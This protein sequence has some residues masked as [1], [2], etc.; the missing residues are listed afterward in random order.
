MKQDNTIKRDESQ[1][2]LDILC[3]NRWEDNWITSINQEIFI[4]I[5]KKNRVLSS[6]AHIILNNKKDN[7]L[8]NTPLYRVL[9]ESLLMNQ[10]DKYAYQE[11][12]NLLQIHFAK[13]QIDSCLLKGISLQGSIPR[14]M[15]DLDLLIHP[16]DLISAIT[17]LE[18]LGFIYQGHKRNI[19]MKRREIRNWKEL[20]TWSNQ[21]EFLH[22]QTGVLVELH[23]NFFER[24]RIY[25]FNLD[26]LLNKVDDFWE[27]CTWSES[28]QCK[29][30]SPED[31][32]LLL[33]IHNSIKR[34]APKGL[35]A[36][37]N[38]LDMKNLIENSKVNWEPLIK[39]AKS[40]NTLT[41]LVYS[42]EMASMFFPHLELNDAISKGYKEL[43]FREKF[44][45]NIMIKCYTNLEYSHYLYSFLFRLFLPLCQKSRFTQKLSSLL[46]LPALFQPKWKL[47]IIYQL[48]TKSK[49]VF[50]TYFLEPIRWVRVALR[51]KNAG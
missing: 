4:N 30:L 22:S 10:R 41:F 45:T 16:K 14:D 11:V 21:F 19:H 18:E 27:R 29:E 50:F 43:K 49:L 28:I 33:S 42:L 36:F 24:Y 15:G 5:A 17:T 32:L 51:R 1:I 40:T 9:K 34:S 26:P 6:L 2:I 8:K 25:R 31:K 20:V 48:P 3:N 44:L 23:T 46:I 37:R 38:I 35:F 39:T 47:R 7:S 12:L 13:K